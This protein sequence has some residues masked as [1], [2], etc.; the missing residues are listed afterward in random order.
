MSS[1]IDL[2]LLRVMQ[3]VDQEGSVTRAAQ[4]LGLSQPAVSNGLAR[5]RRTLGD[6]LFVRSTQRHGGRRRERGG[7]WKRAGLRRWG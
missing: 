7:C 5:L 3:V 6:P 2:N 4:R 1:G